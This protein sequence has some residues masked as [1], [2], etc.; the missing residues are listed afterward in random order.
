M[1]EVDL[2]RIHVV[3]QATGRRYEDLRVARQQLHLLRIRHAAED[4]DGLHAAQVGA[5]LFRSGGHLQRQFSGRGQHQH[6][7]LGR[8]IAR[9]FATGTRRLAFLVRGLHGR[10]RIVLYRNRQL[11][12]GRQHEGSRLAGAGLRRDQQVATFDGRGNGLRLDRGRFGVARVGERLED[13][14]MQADFFKSHQFLSSKWSRVSFRRAEDTDAKN[15][16]PTYEIA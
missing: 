5:V 1:R 4:R 12:H 2:A 8:R 14:R 3:D 13:G 16:A 6:L 15:A 11:V 9:A 10:Q 7:R